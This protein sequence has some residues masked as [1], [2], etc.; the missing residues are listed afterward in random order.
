MRLPSP[1]ITFENEGKPGVRRG[2][3]AGVHPR[4]SATPNTECQPRKVAQHGTARPRRA[5]TLAALRRPSTRALSSDVGWCELQKMLPSSAEMSPPR[6]SR[7]GPGT[8]SLTSSGQLRGCCLL[9]SRSMDSDTRRFVSRALS[10][11]TL[12]AATWPNNERREST[13]TL[14]LF[15]LRRLLRSCDA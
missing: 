14:D 5:R 10:Q 11:A 3:R 1:Q 2:L 4:S 8:E 15:E 12:P 13:C 9:A 6:A 7:R